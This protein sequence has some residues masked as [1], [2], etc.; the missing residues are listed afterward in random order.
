MQF[1]LNRAALAV[2]STDDTYPQAARA[3]AVRVILRVAP[4]LV[5]L[6]VAPLALNW[7][8]P[9][10][11]LPN[12]A[13]WTGIRPLEEKLQKLSAFTAHGRSVDALIVGS[14]ISD[15]GLNAQELSQELSQANGKPYRVFNFS[16][17][18]AELMTMPTLYRM[19]RTVSKPH[20][21]LVALPEEIKRSDDLSPASPDYT[22]DRAPVGTAIRHPWLFPIER[23]IWDVP[24]V[25]DAAPFRDQ[26]VFGRFKNLA[27]QGADLYSIDPHG[28]SLSYS[29]QTTQA[30]LEYLRDAHDHMLAPLT[31]R[32][33]ATWTEQRKLAYFFNDVDI[34]ALNVLKKLTH[35]DGCRIVIVATDV[36]SDYYPGQLT[37]PT[38]VRGRRQFFAVVSSYLHAKL[39]YEVEHFTAQKYMVMDDVHLNVYG[40]LAFTHLVAT[41]LS[42]GRVPPARPQRLES[43]TLPDIPS[44]DPTISNFSFL[45][46]PPK[47]G[48]AWTLHLTILRNH[49]I[50]ALPDAPLKVALRLPDNRDVVAPARLT[51]QTTIVA[52]F[53]ALPAGSGRIY[54]GRIVYVGGGRLNAPNQPIASYTWSR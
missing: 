43:P 26:L 2:G 34:N 15:F 45:V 13:S 3:G 41:G 8:L 12:Y 38:F 24:L 29:Y 31:P 52:R 51:S 35:A 36:A 40:A 37:D 47:Q 9:T 39:V 28:D 49:S 42:D 25:H 5:G 7:I 18:G 22:L 14:S 20:V 21:L 1:R 32:Q 48:G 50:P 11:H 53:P 44:T 6:A 17:G 33:L 10:Q 30:A 16:T 23:R 19:A 27:Q 46:E 54:L 4:F